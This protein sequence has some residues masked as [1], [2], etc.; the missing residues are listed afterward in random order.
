MPAFVVGV[1]R[2]PRHPTQAKGTTTMTNKKVAAVRLVERDEAAGVVGLPEELRVSL[3]GIAGV[4]R[5]GLLAMGATV[6]FLV[7]HEMMNAEMTAKVGAAKHAKVADREAN[8]HG[9][10]PGSVVLGG[11]RVPV[12][13]PRGRTTDRCEIELDTYATF[14]NDDLLSELVMERMLAGV[15][16]R[17]HVRVNEPVGEELAASARSTSRSSVSRRFKTATQAGLDELMSRDLSELKLAALMLDG[18]HFAVWVPETA[19]GP[20]SSE[21]DV[22]FGAW[23]RRGRVEADVS[24]VGLAVVVGVQAAW[25]YSL[26][27]PLQVGCRRIGWPGR[28]S[29]TS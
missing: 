12:Q 23:V 18:V 2:P 6:G 26:M 15:A 4:A 28:Y 9:D 22:C 3:A 21:G 20:F 19:C 25:R 7:M 13:R 8:W 14:T 27:S 5:E 11:R 24:L 10:A 29:T 17:R 1:G 16:T